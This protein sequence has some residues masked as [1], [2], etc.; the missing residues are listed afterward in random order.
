[1]SIRAS[2][3][4][5]LALLL[6]AC[7]DPVGPRPSASA[8]DD[9]RWLAHR[10][11]AR[12][13]PDVTSG[14]FPLTVSFD[15]SASRLG[16]GAVTT[17]WDFGDGVVSSAP[18]SAVH[19]Y[20][21]AGRF[22]ATLTLVDDLTDRVSTRTVAIDVTLP[23]CP[24]EVPPVE[25]GRVVDPGLNELSGLVSSRRDPEAFW[26]HE[27]GGNPSVLVAI[28]ASGSTLSEHA[29]PATLTDWEDLQAAID[30]ATGTP[31]VFLADIGDN[32]RSRGSVSVWV[33]DEPDPRVDGPLAAHELE[34]TYPDG[35]HD[36]ET[37]LVDP[38]TFDLYVVTKV[39]SGAAGLYVKRAPHD[40]AGA[41]VLEDLGEPPALALTA[42]SGDVS[43]DGTRVV[44]RDYTTTALLFRRDGYLPLEDALWTAPCEVTLHGEQQG[45]AIGFTADGAALV[46]TSE[47]VGEPVF[48]IGL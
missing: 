37:L 18:G 33:A 39:S 48:A 42:T 13:R 34:L 46:T 20:V 40:V 17:T 35:P 30:P 2:R 10:L 45:E 8:P 22:D 44:V 1:M 47:G 26:A 7:A 24:S 28:D 43:P 25:W 23:A 12:V 32:A 15:A 31:T 21:G 29:L 5:P 3:A 27:D 16:W 38:L 6:A 41:S 4:L 14:G 9:D 11:V 19:T 36:A